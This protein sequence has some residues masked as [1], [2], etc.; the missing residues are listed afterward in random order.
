MP[1]TEQKPCVDPATIDEYGA[2]SR[3]IA[4]FKPQL[5]RAKALKAHIL[6]WYHDL[7]PE[8]TFVSHGNQ[9]TLQVSARSWEREITSM[10]RL[11]RTLGMKRFFACVRA[12]LGE[13][14]KH[15]PEA[16]QGQFLRKERTGMRD[17]V[18]VPKA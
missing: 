2:V 7:P 1:V 14:D 4:E 15:V 3:A 16:E 5:D 17:I 10:W 18:A 6:G 11:Y 12:K 9:Y 13:I 8:E